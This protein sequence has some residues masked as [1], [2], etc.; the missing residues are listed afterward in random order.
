MPPPRKK[1]LRGDEREENPPRAPQGYRGHGRV[2]GGCR[3][4]GAPPG[5]AN[6][7][8]APHRDR[9]RA[10]QRHENRITSRPETPLIAER[11]R[12]LDGG[13]ICDEREQASQIA[14]CIEKIRI[15]SR[16]VSS[17]RKP[18][19][20]YRCARRNDDER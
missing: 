11:Q 18:M 17:P 8:I 10:R 13:R 12:G 7:R 4:G 14:R 15:A 9:T 6:R 5:P 3:S 2:S 19:L 1:R 16:T 20:Q